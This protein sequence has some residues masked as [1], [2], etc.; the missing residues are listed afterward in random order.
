MD[1]KYFQRIKE[2]RLAK[3]FTQKQLAEMASISPTSYIAYE[4]G[5]K[6]PPIDVAA[7]I[8]N[9]LEVS[10]DWLFGLE[11][12]NT[13][14][15]FKSMADVI[16]AFLPSALTF[17]HVK[18]YQKDIPITEDDTVSEYD[19]EFELYGEEYENEKHCTHW[20][21]FEIR[22]TILAN[23]FQSWAKLYALYINGDIEGDMYTAW[24]EK[25]LGDMQNSPIPLR[26]TLRW[27]DKISKDNNLNDENPSK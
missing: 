12:K 27:D 26:Q 14:V 24:V 11:T 5:N 22:N 6:T 9:C 19:K 10:I 7:R 18:M 3:G 17:E 2:R 4:R 20:A 23:F 16:E 1:T 25:R 13:S 8:A 15:E 21:V